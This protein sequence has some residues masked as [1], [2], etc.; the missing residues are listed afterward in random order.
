MQSDTYKIITL[1]ELHMSLSVKALNKH[2]NIKDAAIELGISDRCLYHWMKK[3][4]I[5]KNKNTKQYGY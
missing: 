4:K 1:K 3:Y 2:D 5:V